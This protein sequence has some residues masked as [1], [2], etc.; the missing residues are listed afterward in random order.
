MVGWVWVWV[1]VWVLGWVPS[2]GDARRSGTQKGFHRARDLS[3]ACRMQQQ[4]ATTALIAAVTSAADDAA[5]ATALSKLCDG[6][7]PPAPEAAT[8]LDEVS[9]DIF[10]AALRHAASSHECRGHAEQL[11]SGLCEAASAR[12]LFCMVMDAFASHSEPHVQ[13]LLLHTLSKVLPRLQRKRPGF[14]V[15]CLTTLRARYFDAWP[16]GEWD[17]EQGDA[18]GSEDP[19][20]Q[21]SQKLLASLT[22][23]VAPF[24]AD[25]LNWFDLP[26][27]KAVRTAVQEETDLGR[28]L[29]ITSLCSILSLAAPTDSAVT[30]RVHK[31]LKD[32]RLCWIDLEQRPAASSAREEESDGKESGAE[33]ALTVAERGAVVWPP[34]SVGLYI[35]SICGA[36][37]GHQRGGG[38]AGEPSAA[39]HP[40]VSELRMATPEVRLALLCPMITPMLQRGGAMAVAGHALLAWACKGAVAGSLG[41]EE[42]KATEG[43]D[44]PGRAADSVASAARALLAHM[45]SDPQ[46]AER[47]AAYATL[48]D[49]L[50]L[51]QDVPRF[52]LLRRLISGCPFPN[53]VALLVH[54]LKEEHLREEKSVVAAAEG[55][56]A[57][58]ESGSSGGIFS[59]QAVLSAVEPLLCVRD[60]GTDDPLHSLD[61]WMAAL[62]LAKFLLMRAA[63][64]S[65]SSS[66]ATPSA[67]PQQARAALLALPAET[68]SRLR[69]THLEP[70]DRWVRHHM[71]QHWTEIQAAEARVSQ[72]PMQDEAL[73]NMRISFTHLHVGAEEA[74]RAIELCGKAP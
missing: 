63:A 6:V 47:T 46:Q 10:D 59:A 72:Q 24:A 28:R 58:G 66:P 20:A 68:A 5:A 13:L 73:A 22:E 48:R 32:C 16:G 60:A 40:I 56:A 41:P 36:A 42:G 12:E 18:K 37:D 17:D 7:L 52:R 43:A 9:F 1:T 30:V 64:S 31:A 57:A 34:P 26:H 33:A 23:C 71:D 14:I 50:W 53:A 62:N 2:G 4:S 74:A 3:V 38:D 54:R 51:W 39:D 69:R 55:G 65:S 35:Q 19:S 27:S 49:L 21:L 25:A 67:T 45:A 44:A 15:S 8:I 29:V 70:L 61:A 11:L